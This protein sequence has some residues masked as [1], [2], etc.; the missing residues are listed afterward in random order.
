MMKTIHVDDETHKRL[1]LLKVERGCVS[2]DELFQ[3]FF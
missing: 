1:A 3:T 2:F